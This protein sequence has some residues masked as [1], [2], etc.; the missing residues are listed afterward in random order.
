MIDFI[1][2]LKWKVCYNFKILYKIMISLY[3]QVIWCLNL[4]AHFD[5]ISVVKRM[6]IHMHRDALPDI[7]AGVGG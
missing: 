5:L 3:F 6:K 2:D 4:I 1:A 7:Q